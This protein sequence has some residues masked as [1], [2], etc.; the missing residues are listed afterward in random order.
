MERYRKLP[1]RFATRKCRSACRRT[2][3]RP[4]RQPCFSRPHRHLVP[5][6]YLEPVRFRRRTP[7]RRRALRADS[8]ADAL[9]DCHDRRLCRLCRPAGSTSSEKH[10]ESILLS[11]E[12]PPPGGCVHPPARGRPCNRACFARTL[13]RPLG[14]MNRLA[15]LSV[16]PH[17][18]IQWR[19]PATP[20]SNNICVSSSSVHP[21]AHVRA[22]PFATRLASSPHSPGKSK[23]GKARGPRTGSRKTLNILASSPQRPNIIR[24]I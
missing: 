15:I 24:S 18:S 16:N 10:V 2:L 13:A 17:A 3:R 4:A 5:H 11:C 21:A 22:A 8:W 1:P 23:T 7:G 20:E 19:S 14:P 9:A 12:A 6:A